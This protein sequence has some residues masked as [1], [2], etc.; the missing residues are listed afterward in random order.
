MQHLFVSS[1]QKE[2]VAERRAL[3]DFVQGDPLLSRFFT[4]FLFEDYPAA[5]R[6]AD[7]VYLEHVDKC[8][9]YVALLGNDYGYEDSEGISPTQREYEYASR[10]NK[11]RLIFISSSPDAKRHAKMRLLVERAGTEL[12]RRRFGTIPELITQVYASLVEYLASTGLIR[13][14]PFDS[15]ACRNAQ[16]SDISEENV[17]LFLRLARKGRGFV[18]DEDMAVKDA[19]TH[20]NLLDKDAPSHA[21]ILLFGKAP[22][23][24][25]ISSEIKC[26]H[27]H[28]VEVAKP[29]PSY[30]IYKG[31]V[32]E[33]VD[34]AVDFVLSKLNRSV[35]TRELGTRAPVSYDIPQNVVAEAI[36][37]AVAHRDYASNGSVQV[38]LFSDRLEVW[39]PGTLPPG[40]TLESLRHPHPS[41]PGNPLIAEPLFLTKYIEKAGSGTVDVIKACSQ[42]GLSQPDFRMENGWF[43]ITLWRALL[44]TAAGQVM[45]KDQIDTTLA[46][47]RNH[48][49][50]EQEGTKLG[51]SRDQVV[52]LFQLNEDQHITRLMKIVGRSNRTKFRD[53]VLLPLI[54]S[55][56]IEMTIP[57]KPRSSLQKYRLTEKGRVFVASVHKE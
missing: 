19:L 17:A 48:V 26:M 42:A 37:N 54:H 3:K 57:D 6:R 2:F 13:T 46:P 14:I 41:I 9:V 35:G 34:Q 22:Q 20:L 16:I 50:I 56:L 49:G 30:Q 29:I 4:V 39:N 51:L 32:F 15:T 8:S 12:V 31:T 43:I 47:S 5:D 1:V 28:G 21:A 52:V 53:Q 38:M 44:A 55:H 45:V 36:V 11:H 7:E 10:R 18:L 40:I 25:L 24:F 27:F 23:R 33:L